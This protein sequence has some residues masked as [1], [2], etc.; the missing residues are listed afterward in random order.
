MCIHVFNGSCAPSSRRRESAD[1]S[2]EGSNAAVPLAP[3]PARHNRML[4]GVAFAPCASAGEAASG[5]VQAVS[6]QP[7]LLP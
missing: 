7:L 3:R 5:R 1:T 6:T 2:G 4:L